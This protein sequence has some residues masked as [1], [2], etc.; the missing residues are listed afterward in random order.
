VK[1]AVAAFV[2]LWIGVVAATPAR[3]AGANEWQ[4]A[5]RLGIGRLNAVGNP[6]APAAGVDV[7]YGL[8]DAWALRASVEGYNDSVSADMA[9]GIS[10]GTE[11]LG[12]ALAGIGYTVDVLRLVPYLTFE[13]GIAHIGGPLAASRTMLA[14]ELGAGGDYYV[15]RQLR[16]GLSFQYLYEPGDLLSDPTHFGNSPFLFSATA[17]VSWVF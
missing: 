9:N 11:R 17:R 16:V 10:A 3:A 12:A 13:L 15:T 1:P 14:S 6:W 7:E 5:L 2:A 8:D 4:A